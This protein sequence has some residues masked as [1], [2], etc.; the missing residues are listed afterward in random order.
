MVNN[1]GARDEWVGGI[2]PKER[3]WPCCQ[4][5]K[6][7]RRHMVAN[8][9]GGLDNLPPSSLLKFSINPNYIRV[10]KR[11]NSRMIST[12]CDHLSRSLF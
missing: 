11:K 5:I 3:S 1:R 10:A 12:V 6:L 8:C 7:E 4:E 9:G 2:V